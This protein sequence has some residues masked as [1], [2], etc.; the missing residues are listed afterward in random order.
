LDFPSNFSTS[1]LVVVVVMLAITLIPIIVIYHR[2][3]N[4]EIP[5]EDLAA[6]A[7]A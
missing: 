6:K 3:N 5:S 7:E 4:R 2:S 1:N